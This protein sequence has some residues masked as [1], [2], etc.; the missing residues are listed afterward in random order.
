MNI[1]YVLLGPGTYYIALDIGYLFKLKASNFDSYR[2]IISF[3][4]VVYCLY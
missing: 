2:L 1:Y 3:S 4:I